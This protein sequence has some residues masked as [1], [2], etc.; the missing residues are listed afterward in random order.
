M[1]RDIPDYTDLIA[2]LEAGKSKSW[3][4]NAA[5]TQDIEELRAIALEHCRWWNTVALPIIQRA[6]GTS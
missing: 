2:A 1:S 5:L 6:K 3:V 4:H